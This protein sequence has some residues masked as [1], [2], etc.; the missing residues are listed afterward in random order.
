MHHVYEVCR[1]NL[2]LFFL[3]LFMFIRVCFFVFLFWYIKAKIFIYF[4]GLGFNL[5]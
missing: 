4:K 3:I 5:K 1:I 2:E